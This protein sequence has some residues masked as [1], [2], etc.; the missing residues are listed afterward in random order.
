[1]KAQEGQRKARET[2]EAKLFSE[3]QLAIYAV[4]QYLAVSHCQVLLSYK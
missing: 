3:E 1:M 2:L 4:N